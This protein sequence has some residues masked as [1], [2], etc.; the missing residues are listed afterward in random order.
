M[1]VLYCAFVLG[2]IVTLFMIDSQTVRAE[3][4]VNVGCP[5]LR[6][7]TPMIYVQRRQF[8]PTQGEE[9]YYLVSLT[10]YIIGVV[11]GEIFLRVGFGNGNDRQEKLLAI[12]G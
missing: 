9:T 3:V 2:V 8:L 5:S 11:E 1:K 12:G 6:R 10:D 7:S 4:N